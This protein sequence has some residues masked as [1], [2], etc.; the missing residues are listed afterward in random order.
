MTRRAVP[1]LAAAFLALAACG[2]PAEPKPAT[3]S[4]AA[5]PMTDAAAWK[6]LPA[7]DRERL[8]T[9]VVVRTNFAAA[10]A[11]RTS[12]EFL[13]ERGE[14]LALADVVK[15]RL[16]ADPVCEWAHGVR[17]EFEVKRRIA[18]CLKECELAEAEGLASVT[19]LQKQAEGGGPLKWVDAATSKKVDD[20]IAAVRADDK[21]LGDPYEAAVQKWVH[22][23]HGFRVMSGLAELHTTAGPYLV[24]VSFDGGKDKKPPK[25]VESRAKASLER[26]AR[27]LTELYDTWTK[28]VAGPLK[29][30]VWSRENL[31][32]KTLLKANVFTNPS[33]YWS[34]QFD[35]DWWSVDYGSAHYVDAEPR[36]LASLDVSQGK[37]AEAALRREAVRQFLHLHTWQETRRTREGRA[38]DWPQCLNRPLW[39]DTGFPWFFASLLGASAR[40][41]GPPPS[42]PWLADVFVGRGVAEAKK[43]KTWTLADLLAVKDRAELTAAARRRA[44]TAADAG[45]WP[46]SELFLGRA[47]SFADFLWNAGDTGSPK[48]R[49][50]YLAYLAGE[51]VARTRM[52]FRNLEV[53]VRPGAEDLRRAL[54]IA[55]DAEFAALEQ[56]WNAYE[57]K[58]LDREKEPE[59]EMRVAKTLADMETPR[60]K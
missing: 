58:L 38:L 12:W 20:L 6:A 27:V 54:G 55:G 60:P 26:C 33:D 1:L 5:D 30:P 41:G 18:K 3:G 24:F 52:D 14:D 35:V 7:S 28:E 10:E 21:R 49:E 31:D 25:D 16:A 48:Y 32:E 15:R 17:G 42:R 8:A 53:C 11:A 23:Q 56:E 34:F 13:K 4:S 50:R 19:E 43:W 36:F 2:G 44:G 46:L 45:S 59:W 22:W 39:S 47:A 9:G 57:A 51:M 37:G 40:A 29:L